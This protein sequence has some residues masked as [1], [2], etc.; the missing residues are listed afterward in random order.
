[1]VGKVREVTNRLWEVGHSEDSGFPRVRPR[2]GRALSRGGTQV[3]TG[4]L[5][6]LYSSLLSCLWSPRVRNSA[7]PIPSHPDPC[8]QCSLLVRSFR[9]RGRQKT[10]V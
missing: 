6:H 5:F 10:R 9:F 3:F 8:C 4:S 7:Q 2:R 1:M